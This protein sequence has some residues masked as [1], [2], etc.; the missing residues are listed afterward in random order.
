MVIS[1]VSNTSDY[2]AQAQA[3]MEYANYIPATPVQPPLPQTFTPQAVNFPANYP[4]AMP[5]YENGML[6]SYNS[7]SMV[8]II[9]SIPSGEEVFV[10]IG[11]L[12]N[13]GIGI[14]FLYNLAR[15][16]L[17]CSFEK[18]YV[19]DSEFIVRPKAVNLKIIN[20]DVVNSQ[21]PQLTIPESSNGF[22]PTQSCVYQ[23]TSFSQNYG[24][25]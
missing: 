23:D 13:M 7:S 11:E 4:Q 22:I 16:R 1:V 8:G 10:E 9:Q 3:Q 18:K 19:Y 6:I 24:Y 17:M 12:S 15:I 20:I 14:D 2:D 25:H 5:N 21:Q